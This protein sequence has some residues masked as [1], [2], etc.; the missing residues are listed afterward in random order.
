MKQIRKTLVLILMAVMLWGSSSNVQA[1]SFKFNAIAEKE[2]VK[3]GSV[4]KVD[5]EVSNIEVK[6]GINVI[7]A[8][9]QY[10]ETIFESVTFQNSDEWASIYHSEEGQK[11]GKFLFTKAVEGVKQEEKIGEIQLKLKDNLKEM[12]TEI[13]INK[14]TSNDGTQL[15]DEGNR[16]VKIKIVDQ[17][18]DSEQ[19]DKNDP[20]QGDKKDPE[21]D[22]KKDPE[23]GDKKEPEQSEKKDETEKVEQDLI[24]TTYEQKKAGST[25][26]KETGETDTTIGEEINTGDAISLIVIAVIILIAINIAYFMIKGK[27]LQEEGKEK[28]RKR[29]VIL[30]VVSLLLMTIVVFLAKDVLAYEGK[31][32]EEMIQLLKS[33]NKNN[34]ESREYLVTDQTISRIKPETT[35]EVAKSKLENVVVIDTAET[36]IVKTGMTAKYEENGRMYEISVLGDINGDGILNQIELTRVIREYLKCE[37]W[38]I[39]E[40]VERLSADVNCDGKIDEKDVRSIVNYIVYGK[41]E[42]KEVEPVVAPKVEVVSGKQTEEGNYIARATIKITQENEESKTEKTIY[43]ITGS[44]TIEET[45]IINQEEMIELAGN[46]VYKITGYTYGKDGNKSKGTD[47]IVVIEE[48]PEIEVSTKEWTNKKVE[49][50]IK[51]KEGYGIEYKINEGDWTK[52]EG[53]VEVEENCTIMARFANPT[54]EADKSKIVTTEITNIDTKIPTGKIEEVE[55]KSNIIKVKVQGQD[56]ELSGID[57]MKIYAKEKAQKEYNCVKTYEYGRNGEEYEQKEEIYDIE[58]L[59]AQTTYNIYIEVTDKAGNHYSNKDKELEI[60]TLKEPDVTIQA[61]PI[62]WTKENVTATLIMPEGYEEEGYQIEY[63]LSQG[64]VTEEVEGWIIYQKESIITIEENTTIY[65]RLTKG[66]IKEKIITKPIDNIDKIAP[67]D[68]IPTTTKTTNSI[69]LTGSTNDAEATSQNASTGIEKY[70]FSKD[71]GVTWEPTEGQTQT[72]YTFENLTQKQAYSLKMKAVDK[73]GNERVTKTVNETTEAV[74]VLNESNVNFIYSDTNWTNNEY[75]EV[76]I[77]SNKS[78]Y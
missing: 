53:K 5:M 56:Q 23:Q 16:T 59:K 60:E 13:K 42:T 73:V 32:L 3:V 74:P 68:F 50:T 11:K 38:R 69:T 10:D 43:E 19:D 51:E 67:V 18:K 9:L 66:E 44:E 46:G 52:Y 7:E 70:Y 8:D 29:M 48:L 35:T 2:E 75:V 22:D 61:I 30:A 37:D 25:S 33:E 21:Q 12:E 40:E 41:L 71:D 6:D 65:A 39:E 31:E 20:E 15:I 17:E 64:E 55:K 77:R 63:I 54:N 45:E 78:E 28:Y 58:G 24:K 57:T 49:V 62:E 72:S 76:T 14:I 34:P 1:S 47:L 27:Q 4:V 26:E 36:E